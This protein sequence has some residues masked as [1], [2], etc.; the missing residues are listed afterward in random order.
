MNKYQEALDNQA[1][2]IQE[3]EQKNR[4]NFVIDL[5]KS[6]GF[7]CTTSGLETLQE[8]VERATPK[9]VINKFG[10]T[11]PNCGQETVGPRSNYCPD[12]GQALANS[13]D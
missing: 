2:V 3:L 10:W 9:S 8:L 12:C 13:D 5:V 6:M 4:L 11:C 1:Y 7:N